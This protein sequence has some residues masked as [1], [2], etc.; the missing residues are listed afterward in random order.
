MKPKPCKK[1]GRD[2]PISVIIGGVRR[3]LRNRANCLT[4]VPFGESRYVAKTEEG[5][6]KRIAAKSRSYY[7]RYKEIHGVDKIKE[8]RNRYR[9]H[10]IDLLSG[11]CQ[12]CGYS[13]CYRNLTFHHTR[14]KRLRLD[15]RSFQFALQTLL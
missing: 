15:E 2:I 8:R 7:K 3:V 1:C 13:R 6:R 5:R 11:N 9:R 14:D 10:I 12:I 4:C